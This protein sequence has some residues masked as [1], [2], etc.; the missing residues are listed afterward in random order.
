[1]VHNVREEIIEQIHQGDNAYGHVM[2]VH[3]DEKPQI[4]RG[5]RFKNILQAVVLLTTQHLRHFVVLGITSR[6]CDY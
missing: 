5:K 1:M 2:V 3:N 4:R 6:H